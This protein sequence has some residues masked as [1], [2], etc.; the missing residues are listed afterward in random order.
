MTKKLI[1]LLGDDLRKIHVPS[2][3]YHKGRLIDFPF[4]PI[5]LLKNIGPRA[6]FK[7]FFQVIWQKMKK[8]EDQNNFEKFALKTYGKEL[9]NRFL[10]NYSEKLW[11][12]P[13]SS[14]STTISGKRL[15]GLSL[16]SVMLEFLLGHRAKTEHL[17]GTTFYYPRKGFGKISKK[18][19]KY[20]GSENI[21][22]Q[23]RVTRIDHDPEKKK[24]TSIQINNSYNIVPSDVINTLPISLFLT[25]M[26]PKPPK[27]I[28][29]LASSLKY[30]NMMLVFIAIDTESLTKNATVY[31]PDQ[32]YI[33]TRICEPRNRC[34]LMSPKGK[35]SLLVEIPCKENDS[36]WLHSEEKNIQELVINP[37]LNIFKLP[38]SKVLDQ[39]TIKLDKAYP[40][41][42][43]GIEKKVS[44]IMDFLSQYPN[45][46]ISGRNGIFEYIHIHDLMKMAKEIVDKL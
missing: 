31:F 4:S 19:E 18:F 37:I 36:I 45:L 3:V 42:E 1:A 21:K 15:K 5:N 44:I 16:K 20:C 30:R 41:L 29:E 25:M 43:V 2:Q 7:S 34:P 24:I 40:I 8:K 23:A 27:E 26:N 17:E 38:Q 11:G 6:F 13:C 12:L 28:L 32:E 35:T 14:L 39:C 9:A 46:H 33:F 22:K 10:L